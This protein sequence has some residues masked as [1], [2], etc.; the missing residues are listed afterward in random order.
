MTFAVKSS[1]GLGGASGMGL[2]VAKALAARGGWNI[3]LL[4]LNAERVKEAAKEVT[5][6]TFHQTNVTDYDSLAETFQNDGTKN[7]D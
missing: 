2:A 6:S 3:H 4:D 1:L 7:V 5:G